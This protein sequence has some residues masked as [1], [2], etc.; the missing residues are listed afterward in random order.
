MARSLQFNKISGPLLVRGPRGRSGWRELARTSAIFAVAPALVASVTAVGIASIRQSHTTVESVV[1]SDTPFTISGRGH[2]HG[3]GMGQWGAFGYARDHGWGAERIVAHYYGDTS[4]ADLAEAQISVRLTGLDDQNLGAYSDTGAV[5]AGTPVGPGEA[6]YLTPTPGGGAAVTVTRGCGG[7]VLWQGGTDH[8]WVDPIDLSP[9]RP[10]EQHLKTCNGYTSYR[11]S[12]GVALDGGAPRVV[13]VVDMEDYLLSVV[14]AESRAEW[15]DQGGS[16]A[17]R[18]QA[19]AARSYAAAEARTEYAR[20]CDSQN[21]QVYKGSSAEDPRTSE[22]V[23][24]TTSLIVVR[25]GQPI[26]TEFSSSTGGFSSGGTFPAVEDLGDAASPHHVWTEVVTAGTIANTFGVGE[27]HSVEVIERNNVGPDGGRVVTLRVNGSGGSVDVPGM[28]ARFAL[29]LK[30]DWFTVT[31]GIVPGLEPLGSPVHPAA[32]PDG[33]PG[34]DGDVVQPASDSLI[35]RKFRELGGVNG[36]LGAPLG[37]ELMLPDES[38]T[39]RLYTGGT[40][41]WTESLGVRVIDANVLREVLPD[42]ASAR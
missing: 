3:R 20:T 34:I 9:D 1:A 18:A 32:A 15:A 38:G 12:L 4:L 7:E 30:S 16:E 21:C 22:A 2:G 40:I 29:G 37:P 19:I 42:S 35:D 36:H 6:V 13:N 28:E 27:L 17:L 8:P 14:P 26:A 25:D 31:E 24:T 39:F 10:H 11:G 5:V 23:R 33:E 41:L